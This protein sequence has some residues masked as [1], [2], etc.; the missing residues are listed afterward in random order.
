[1]NREPQ[2]VN[3]KHSHPTEIGSSGMKNP[4]NAQRPTPNAQRPLNAAKIARTFEERSPRIESWKLGV[5]RW[6]LGVECRL[7]A[8]DR[9]P[10]R[11]SAHLPL[12]NLDRTFDARKRTSVSTV[13]RLN[14]PTP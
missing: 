8:S 11:Q 7:F 12:A 4:F 6:V 9:N 13:A 2:T 1:V 5:G 3:R 14:D 10:E